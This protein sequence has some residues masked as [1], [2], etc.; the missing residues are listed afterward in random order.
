MLLITTG[1][2]VNAAQDFS[3]AEIKA[4]QVS[5]DVYMLEGPGGNIGVLATDEGLLLVDDKF[6]PLATKIEQA[7]TSI[8]SAPL[9]Y[10]VN[11]HY[12]GDHTGSNAHFAKHAPIFAHSNVRKRVE[13]DNKK[14]GADLP[15]VTYEQ[16]V[17]IHLANEKIQLLHLPS[18]HTDGDSVVYFK[19]AN[20]IH[21]GDLF[22][23]GRFPYIDLKAGGTVKGYL[24][25][26]KKVASSY[27]K[28][29]KIIPGHGVLTDMAGLAEFIAMIEYSVEHI[30]KAIKAGNSDEQILKAGIGDKYKSWSWNFITEERW[31]KTLTADLR[32]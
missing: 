22:F 14:S 25:N 26:I 1:I 17:T 12:H 11:T 2:K 32:K 9:K 20:V 21:M 19:Q 31:I 29:I 16:G 3:K 10:V 7:M 28:D 27:P 5:G 15:V 4:K 24:A 30:E 6:A 23:Q 13:Q 18:G 8:K